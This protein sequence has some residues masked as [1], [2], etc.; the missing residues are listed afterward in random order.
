MYTNWVT[1]KIMSLHVMMN[2]TYSKFVAQQIKSGRNGHPINKHHFR[3]QKSAWERSFF[4]E[5]CIYTLI[6]KLPITYIICTSNKY[7]NGSKRFRCEVA[8]NRT[9]ASYRQESLD[10]S[11]ETY[12][13]KHRYERHTGRVDITRVGEHCTSQPYNNSSKVSV[14]YQD[15]EWLRSWM[16]RR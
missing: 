1:T 3:L 14:R 11:Q 13:H 5:M 15:Q 10:H 2:K 6:M 9:Q 7:L 12:L 16:K 4:P 8:T